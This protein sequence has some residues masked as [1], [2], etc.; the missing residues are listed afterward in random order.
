MKG[1]SLC[2][3]LVLLLPA[4]TIADEK[5]TAPDLMSQTP[6]QVA[7]KNQNCVSCH[8]QTDSATMH[9]SDVPLACVDC[10]GGDPTARAKD[11]AHVL[12][13]QKDVFATSANP[14]RS[15][16]RI[17][18]EDPAYARFVNP[19]DLRVADVTCGASSCHAQ[20]VQKV[21]TSMMTHG[22]SLWAAALY[23][24]GAMPVKD[25]R[26]GESYGRDGKPQAL[27]RK[28]P[29]TPEQ[30]QKKGILGFLTPLLRWE[31]SQPSNILRIFEKG[32][33]KQLEIGDPDPFEGDPPGKPE[34]RLS[35]R[36]PGTLNRTDPVFIG[37]QKTRL[38]GPILSF[39]GTNDH[40]GDYRAGGCTACHV[41]YANDRDPQHSGPWAK[42]GNRGLSATT[43]PTIPK[44]EPGHPIEHKFTLAIP[45][46]QCVVCHLHPGTN[47]VMTYYGSMWWDN[48][49]DGI[50]MYPAE[51]K[52]PTAKQQV[53]EIEAA[54]PEGAAVRGK[55]S[56][57]TFLENLTDLN[58][59]LEKTQFADFHGH[60]WVFRNIYKQN[61]KGDLLD[62]RGK[63]VPWNDPDRFKKAVHLADIHLEKG[64]HCVDCH[65]EQDSHGDGELY[66]EVRNAIEIGCIDCHGSIYK[67]ADPT[68]RTSATTGPAGPNK[69]SRYMRT[70]FGPRFYKDGGKL[71][72]RSA[73]T[74]DVSWEVV[75]TLDTIDPA[76]AHYNEASRLAKTLRTDG[77]SWGSV[78]KE[79][80]ELAHADENM[81]CFACHSSWMTSCFGCHLPQ[82][83]NRRTPMLHNEGETL[84]NW[85]S[86]N[87]QVLR[88]DVF[89]LGR[90]G[91][92][93]GGRISPVR[94]SS[95]LVVSSQNS[96]REWVYTQQ[97]T[98]SAEGFAGQAFNT[99]VPH[100]VRA[101][102][103]KICSDCHLSAKGD[104]NAVMAQLL[105]LGTNFVNF[106]GR[107]A[108][109]GEG[110]E[111][112][113][114]VAVTERDEPQAVIGSELHS[115]AYPSRFREHVAHHRELQEAYE[116]P[117]NDVGDLSW[118][119][120]KRGEVRSIQLRGEYLYAANGRGGLRVYDIANV[121]QKGF[122]ERIVTAPVS[123]LG[124]RLYV[125]TKDATAVAAPTTLGVDPLRSRRPQ[126]EEQPV[127]PMYGYIFVTDRE[128]GLILVG[129][130][131]LLDGNPDNNFLERALTYNPGGIL[132]GAEN[133]AIIGTHAYVACRRG[134]VV[135]SLDDPMHPQVTAEIDAPAVRNVKAIA[136][137]FR[138]AFVVDEMGFK[139]LDITD[140][141][142]PKLIDGAL[143]PLAEPQ[144]VYVA[145]TYAYVAAGRQG[146]A[147]VDV[148][149]PEHPKLDQTFDADGEMNDA[150]AV[151]VGMTNASL[152]AY[153]ADGRNGLR[154]LQLT[155]PT[156]TPGNYG[157]SPR[158]APKL[159]ATY[160]THGPAIALSKGL[161]R[162]RAVDESGNQ[163]AVFGRRGGR[164]FTLEE[165]R[166]LYMKDGK[167]FAVGDSPPEDGTELPFR[168]VAAEAPPPV[169]PRIEAPVEQPGVKLRERG[170]VKL[171]N[172]PGGV[173][174][175]E[176][177][178]VLLRKNPP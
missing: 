172:E 161:D 34:R 77:K 162:D 121:D 64:M 145:R 23:N 37:L 18:N 4:I 114:A 11:V 153:V 15:N 50:E 58:P 76:S 71:F 123:P 65:F 128:E 35:Q 136:W 48:E 105:L 132:D 85:T 122:S 52:Q 42:H 137:Q 16:T 141:A 54:N 6:E 154:V 94:S 78:P 83:A 29:P 111:G 147:I 164:P 47:M 97:Q 36:G 157:F 96:N 45:S 104:N 31:V 81:T 17:L 163:L 90:D 91:S 75:Q 165:M 116:H 142:H 139:V 79:G 32:G 8:T 176:R 72:Q 146:L 28:N 43:D 44:N 14:V 63:V 135:I 5:I 177:S 113:E 151:K 56:D 170:G 115:L 67:Y 13:K 95:A 143:V 46:S 33:R 74:K 119:W 70:A 133:L 7:A 112:L 100:T 169:R 49:T 118:L 173:Q 156:R 62:A 20:E 155:S 88:D 149:R 39:P 92:V 89:M 41:I 40:P 82:Q 144:D 103:T 171:R 22:D 84:R 134:I 26:F 57:E 158:P 87:Y 108:Y 150:R 178:G 106:M 53:Y 131:T 60:G 59:K 3:T 69:L 160:P 66:G 166:R 102:E 152:F 109:V 168:E 10:H 130:A 99:H 61:R 159:V 148:E 120:G 127:H 117:G 27:V 125:A 55:W 80:K 167:P 126:N 174:L 25:A 140:L 24:N 30:T 12:P 129:A 107:F 21:R 1:A 68:D 101:S 138:Y 86:Y 175:R 51:D 19:G 73:V 98:I 110:E 93:V 124:Q 2:W 38:Y 9:E